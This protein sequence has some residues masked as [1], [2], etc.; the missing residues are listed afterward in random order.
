ME[1]QLR[2]RQGRRYDH[3]RHR[4]CVERDADDSAQE[5]VDALDRAVELGEEDPE[6]HYWLGEAWLD[7]VAIFRVK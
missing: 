6:V 7:D 1:E 4:G 2:K 5:A 3:Q